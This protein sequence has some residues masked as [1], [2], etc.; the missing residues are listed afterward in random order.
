MDF[1]FDS[2]LGW[3]FQGFFVSHLVLW[4]WFTHFKLLQH[5][6]V[7][8]RIEGFI[9]V[10]MFPKK[11]HKKSQ[12]KHRPFD[13]LTRHQHNAFIL[14]ELYVPPCFPELCVFASEF[15]PNATCTKA[16]YNLLHGSAHVEGA[17]PLLFEEP[18]L[19]LWSLQDLEIGILT[20]ITEG[21][22]LVLS[23][24]W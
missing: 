18:P 23:S 8:H 10:S 2:F 21:N 19:L 15:Q 4:L 22:L 7:D 1:L 9:L 16:G 5:L 3:S 11:G 14:I 6:N 24:P 17:H 12:K 20:D 13:K